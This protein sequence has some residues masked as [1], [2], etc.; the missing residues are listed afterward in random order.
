MQIQPLRRLFAQDAA[1]KLGPKSESGLSKSEWRGGRFIYFFFF[2]CTISHCSWNKTDCF[3]RCTG[4]VQVKYLAR[5]LNSRNVL[6][7]THV[8]LGPNPV[9]WLDS[10]KASLLLRHSITAGSYS[11]QALQACQAQVVFTVTNMSESR[12]AKE[13]LPISY[14]H[15]GSTKAF[16]S[17][18][19]QAGSPDPDRIVLKPLHLASS[20]SPADWQIWSLFWEA[21]LGSAASP[22]E[23]T[24]WTRLGFLIKGILQHITSVAYWYLPW[25][26]ISTSGP[27]LKK[28]NRK[29]VDF[30]LADRSG[31]GAVVEFG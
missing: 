17:T 29:P 3:Y 31:L 18:R 23:L 4:S 27:A 28:L 24:S 9:L 15:V 13:A 12:P 20:R 2:L 11:N 6:T 8:Q 21:C 5:S 10:Q 19:P 16:C 7:I 22:G 14:A 25:I 1:H 26:R 30:K